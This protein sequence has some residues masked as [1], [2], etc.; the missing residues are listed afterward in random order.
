MRKAIQFFSHTLP[1]DQDPIH[2]WV[3]KSPLPHDQLIVQLA[4][5]HHPI[6]KSP[7]GKPYFPSE[8]I[9]FNLSDT[10]D[11]LAVVFSWQTPV[12]IDIEL[13]RPIDGMD[14]MILDCFSAK[15]QAYV[16]EKNI[17]LRFWEIWNRKEA[18]FKALGLGL[19][20]NMA[21]WECLGPDWTLVNRVWVRSLPLKNNLSGAV[22]FHE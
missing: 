12:G 21:S 11:W 2:V 3:G 13:I 22:A 1:K 10:E 9:H 17:L 7:A 6:E 16:K 20:D 18:C 14:Q 19:Q 8:S 4:G 5:H 15:E